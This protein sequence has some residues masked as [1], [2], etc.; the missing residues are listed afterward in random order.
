MTATD[1]PLMEYVR[2]GMVPPEHQATY[3]LPATKFLPLQEVSLRLTEALDHTATFK[4]ENDKLSLG[5][6]EIKVGGKTGI[7]L[8]QDGSRRGVVIPT[9]PE[10]KLQLLETTFAFCIARALQ[11]NKSSKQNIKLRENLF[12]AAK[13]LEPTLVPGKPFDVRMGIKHVSDYGFTW[14]THTRHHAEVQ[15][16]NV[17]G[18]QEKAIKIW[19]GFN[20]YGLNEAGE[21]VRPQN[22]V[23][24]ETPLRTALEAGNALLQVKIEGKPSAD[25]LD[26]YHQTIL[27]TR[28]AIFNFIAENI[29]SKSKSQ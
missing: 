11:E 23:P 8:Y 20:F 9:S 2:T 7:E 1:R 28:K 5:N 13:A 15:L 12:K 24:L 3:L 26:A 27:F 17:H 18:T 25:V 16:T 22:Y 19:D 4:L 21:S 14:D 29:Q 10:E 6:L